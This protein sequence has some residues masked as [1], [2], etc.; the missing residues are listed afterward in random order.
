MSDTQQL[1]DADYIRE[2]I[3]RSSH[4]SAEAM[5]KHVR[6]MDSIAGKLEAVA[7]EPKQEHVHDED[8]C[9]ECRQ[10]AKS[11]ETISE[12]TGRLMGR[13]EI[14]QEFEA[15]KASVKPLNRSL[16]IS[17]GIDAVKDA[18]LYKSHQQIVKTT[19]ITV[20]AKIAEHFA[21]P[22]CEHKPFDVDALKKYIHEHLNFSPGDLAMQIAEK[23]AT[24]ESKPISSEEAGEIIAKLSLNLQ[25]T[26]DDIPWDLLAKTINQV[27]KLQPAPEEAERSYPHVCDK[28]EFKNSCLQCSLDARRE[29]GEEAERCIE[30]SLQEA[31]EIFNTLPVSYG[32]EE[33]RESV[34]S[35]IK[36]HRERG[37]V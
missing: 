2:E 36:L 16:A 12:K 31:N 32:P 24:P 17:V 22:N 7:Q 25:S 18:L 4:R 29:R 1:S 6:R 5:A 28:D 37:T 19:A 21:V 33:I 8:E 13:F 23:F 14:K 27:L 15:G 35:A 20:A 34:N 3:T 30:I 11:V 26:I 10:L 9:K